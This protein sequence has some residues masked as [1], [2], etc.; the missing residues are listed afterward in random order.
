MHGSHWNVVAGIG[1]I[2]P[3]SKRFFY[4]NDVGA[5]CPKVAC[6]PMFK[7]L[8][9]NAGSFLSL[10]NSISPRTSANNNC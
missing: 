3:S 4:C 7:D 5:I 1:R 2:W 9:E 6:L 10:T 8:A